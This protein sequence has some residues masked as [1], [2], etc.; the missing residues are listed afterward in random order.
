M[1]KYEE[2]TNPEYSGVKIIDVSGV[3]GEPTDIKFHG[4]IKSRIKENLYDGNP[5]EMI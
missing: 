4:L 5:E 1:A 2:R 3:F